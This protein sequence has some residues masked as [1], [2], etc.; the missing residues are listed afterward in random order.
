VTHAAWWLRVFQHPGQAI[1]WTFLDAYESGV[2]FPIA[3]F[4]AE[5]LTAFPDAK[6]ILGV[7]DPEAWFVFLA[8]LPLS[9][10]H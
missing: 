5:L 7:R 2:D 10:P 4:P 9:T 6:F 8:H 3:S 1:D